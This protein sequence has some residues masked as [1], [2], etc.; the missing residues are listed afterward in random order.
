MNV[1]RWLTAVAVFVTAVLGTFTLGA[2]TAQAAECGGVWVVVAGQGTKCATSHGTGKAA[3]QSA[4]FSTKDKSPGFLCQ[5]NGSPAS[6]VITND[7]YWSYWQAT[8]NADG[9]WGKWTYSNLGYTS[10]KPKKGNAEGWVFGN[11]KTPPPAPPKD[12]P[13]PPPAP[14]TSAP[15]PSK[16]EPAPT[17]SAPKPADPKPAPSKPA[18]TKASSAP[19][20]TQTKPAAPA[21]SQPAGQPEAAP[22]ASESAPGEAVPSDS[23]EATPEPEATGSP[24]SAP[25]SLTTAAPIATPADGGSPV[26]TIAT[27]GAIVLGGGGLGAWWFLK[28]RP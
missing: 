14:T 15:A 2:P 17:T 16:P 25:E 18:T 1:R 13:K 12:A 28:R 6:C 4:G 9:T 24:S 27:I 21:V 22:E 10:T 11:G 3:L 19:T 8:K 20:K 7:A 5:I 26:G 23:P